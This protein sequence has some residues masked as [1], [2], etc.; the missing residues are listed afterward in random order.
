MCVCIC[1]DVEEGKH[2]RGDLECS[3]QAAVGPLGEKCRSGVPPVCP[4]QAQG[5][6]ARWSSQSMGCSACLGKFGQISQPGYRMDPVQGN[7]RS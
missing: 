4:S 6:E 1:A 7:Q 5:G 3:D 2:F